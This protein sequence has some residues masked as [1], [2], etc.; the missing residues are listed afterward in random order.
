M[1]NKKTIYGIFNISRDF[2]E[3]FEEAVRD[4]KELQTPHYH[5]ISADH[6]G[7]AEV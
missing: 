2:N 7:T 1:V 3:D 6:T 5:A 4:F